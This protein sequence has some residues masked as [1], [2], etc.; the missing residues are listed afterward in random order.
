MFHTDP[1][2]RQFPILVALLIGQFFFR[3]LFIRN[4]QASTRV[5]SSEALVPQIDA[6][7]EADEPIQRRIKAVFHQ[8][9]IVGFTGV[10]GAKEM[11]DTIQGADDHRFTGMVFFLTAICLALVV[12]V[13]GALNALF[14]GI[15]DEHRIALEDRGEFSGGLDMAQ[16]EQLF[17]LERVM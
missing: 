14:G 15:K 10:G 1:I 7:L 8:R 3:R 11:N 2:A 12:A 4:M 5:V 13:L 6:C 9:V 17:D 16:G